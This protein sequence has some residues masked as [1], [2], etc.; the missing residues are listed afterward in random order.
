MQLKVI[1]EWQPHPHQLPHSSIKI[2][3]RICNG[4]SVAFHWQDIV[5][6]VL[7]F[8][9]N[10]IRCLNWNPTETKISFR[11]LISMHSKRELF[12]IWLNNIWRMSLDSFKMPKW[13]EKLSLFGRKIESLHCKTTTFFPPRRANT[14]DS[15]YRTYL[16]KT[17][18]KLAFF[19]RISWKVEY[20][21]IGQSH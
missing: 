10:W 18:W 1:F 12:H 20:S 21:S 15:E 4:K 6:K 16:C 5:F 3:F 2:A 13:Y 17:V 11:K 8:S 14:F 7:T 9:R 19:I